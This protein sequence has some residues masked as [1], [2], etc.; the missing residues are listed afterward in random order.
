MNSRLVRDLI[1]D[2]Q[3][4]PS[5]RFWE[6]GHKVNKSLWNPRVV[7][8]H[9]LDLGT[10]IL[11]NTRSIKVVIDLKLQYQK[12]LVNNYVSMRVSILMKLMVLWDTVLTEKFNYN[13]Y[14]TRNLQNTDPRYR[15]QKLRS[16]NPPT[17]SS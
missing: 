10:S 3:W 15:V 12:L 1:H 16:W 5:V 8:G 13:H 9:I 4:S 6:K 14:F 11:F 17:S 2:H 7:L